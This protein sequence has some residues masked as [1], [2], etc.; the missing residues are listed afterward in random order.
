MKAPLVPVAVI[1]AAGLWAGELIEAPI[2]GTFVAAACLSLAALLLKQARVWCLATAVLLFGWLNL[3]LRT[4]VVSPVD[5][6]EL[7]EDK[8]LLVTVRGILVEAPVQRVYVHEKNE[9]WRT[10]A[11][12]E[13]REV[14][15]D[16][17]EWR[18]VYGKIL[19]L[20]TG[21]L[22]N[23]F[24]DGQRV[25]VQGVLLKPS[26]PSAPG[27]FDY[28]AHLARRGVYYQLKIESP[29]EWRPLET[30]R[31]PPFTAHFRDWAQR[32]LARGLPEQDEALRLQW[33]MLLGWQTALT[34]EVSEP[35]M[36][37]GT[38]HIFAI[39]GLH[40]ALIAGIFVALLRALTVPR[41]M[42]G[43]I[44]VPLIWFYTAATGWQPS[45]IRST[46]MMTVIICGWALRRPQNLLNS[47]A[48][49][50]LIILVWDPQQL[51]QASFQLSFFV[52]LSI[53][54]LVPKLDTWKNRFIKPDPMLPMQLRP[55]WHRWSWRA[56]E[57]VWKSLCTSLAAFIGSLPLIAYYFHLLTP[58]SLVAN[59][60]VVP[61]SSLALMSGLGS[62]LTA[63]WLPGVAEYF[64]HSGWFFMRSMIWLSERATAIPASWFHVRAPGAAEFTFYYGVLLA[65]LAGGFS[66]PRL[67]WTLGSIFAGLLALSVFRWNAARAN[68]EIV[69]VP[70]NGT[71]AVITRE[72][73]QSDRWLINCG[74]GS[75]FP[76]GLK[77]V[78]Q[79]RGDNGLHDL[80]LAQG[81]TR[82]ASAMFALANLFHVSRIHIASQPSRSA[83]FR[84]LL[85]DAELLA[86]VHRDATN[87]AQ[88]GPWRVL[89][90]DTR[91]H[92]TR[93]QDNAVV[94][95]GAFEG[96]RV[97]LLNGVGLG[98]QNAL[99]DRG[100]ELRAHIVVAELTDS[101]D[102]LPPELIA[103][104]QPKLMVIVDSEFPANRRAS[105]E[106]QSRLRRT[107]I[108]VMYTRN[109][110]A[111]TVT[112]R[113]GSW[114]VT[115]AR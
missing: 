30:F 63:A 27:L 67:R 86:A 50:A 102:P 61:V 72:A 44:V 59:L 98:G 35:F 53:A 110:G 107:G 48:A 95:A 66:K 52:V 115:A 49:A 73:K 90:P 108:P 46:I 69:V 31:P 19:T 112:M 57:I 84:E 60:V 87:G 65:W 51:F 22:T 79:S 114:R 45:A 41:L 104:I 24:C 37:S 78:L 74:E 34:S 111:V 96:V 89:H 47:L 5:V 14:Q 109:V 3:T 94:L 9:S 113:D 21:V 33:A 106:L 2:A 68:A 105:E 64:N 25:E 82:H 75:S 81:D 80:L 101:G 20:T 17:G 62:I 26:L 23:R 97:L 36:R 77:P 43:A 38:M 100:A 39:S 58:G 76:I 15:T 32:E 93:G 6:R 83:R 29:H 55:R 28:R 70:L 99:I 85:S 56:G 54:L 71:S 42:C 103:R 13:L 1:Y 16:S 40:I 88:L 7:A 12:L 4:V 10:V 91:D 92:F 18:P 8:E 11:Q